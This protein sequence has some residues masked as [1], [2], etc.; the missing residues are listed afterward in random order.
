[1]FG[2]YVWKMPHMGSKW[3]GMQGPNGTGSKQGYFTL[4][5]ITCEVG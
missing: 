5:S 2:C 4:T 1:M 3:G